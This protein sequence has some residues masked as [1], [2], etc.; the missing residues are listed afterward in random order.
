[1]QG[2]KR[3]VY[4]GWIASIGLGLSCALISSPARAAGDAAKGAVLAKEWCNSCHTVETADQARKFDAGPQFADLATKSEA[5]LKVAIDKPHDF[6]PKFPKLSSS[7][8]AD[9]IAYIR[10][11]K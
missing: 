2:H 6:M 11:V 1:M 5:Y 8:K 10:S 4:C 3:A 9:L 7:D